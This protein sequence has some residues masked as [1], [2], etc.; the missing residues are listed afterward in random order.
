MSLQS[1]HVLLQ[2]LAGREL[3]L[4]DAGQGID[5][6]RRNKKHPGLHRDTRECEKQIMSSL[7]SSRKVNIEHSHAD[8]VARLTAAV[9]WHWLAL[10]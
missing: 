10:C 1:S 4:A 9:V 8:G 3:T 7:S 2:C 6:A 5:G